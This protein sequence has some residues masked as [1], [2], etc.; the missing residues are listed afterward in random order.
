MNFKQYLITICL[1]TL[2]IAGY[3]KSSIDKIDVKFLKKKTIE[4]K[5]SLEKIKKKV[6]TVNENV[7]KLKSKNFKFV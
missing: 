4:K 6:K 2:I 3:F 7:K 5:E 1:I